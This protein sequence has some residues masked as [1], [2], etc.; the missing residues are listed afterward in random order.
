MTL[1]GSLLALHHVDS[2]TRGLRSRLESAERAL[3]VQVR[4]LEELQQQREELE[5]RQRQLQARIS[6]LDGETTLLEQR[7]EKLRNDLNNASTSKQYNAVL[8]ELST[9]K[10][11]RSQLEERELEHMEQ[12]DEIRARIVAV[13]QE[14][15]ERE[16]LRAA[17]AAEL[18]RRQGDVGQRLGELE[19]ERRNAAA[20][21]PP[22]ALTIFNELADAYEGEAM[23]PIL[24][25]DR[26]HREYACG[27]CHMSLPFES[28]SAL[29]A[30]DDAISRCHACRRIL[31]LEEKTRGALAKK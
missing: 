4:H 11:S 3:A 5:S 16:K 19:A 6:N 1:T 12:L 25:V 15:S 8:A 18:D 14:V 21:V 24:E 27:A 22:R 23:A 30:Q 2:Q 26:R 9:V 28:V 20:V 13:G 7:I 31:Y 10:L 17:A 29:L